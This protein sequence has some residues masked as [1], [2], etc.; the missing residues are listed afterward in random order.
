MKVTYFGA[1]WCPQCKALKPKV[2]AFC[3]DKN[4]EFEYLDAEDNEAKTTELNIRS[5]PTF[6]VYDGEQLMARGTGI[7]EWDTISKAL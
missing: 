3:K 7:A 6:F 1:D 4:I 5:L 2:E